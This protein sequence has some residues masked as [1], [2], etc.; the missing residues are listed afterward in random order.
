MIDQ[1][2]VLP[3]SR[4]NGYA[5]RL[6][7]HAAAMLQLKNGFLFESRDAQSDHFYEKNKFRRVGEWYAYIYRD[8]KGVF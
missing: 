7:S 1:L 8:V 5:V 6:L 4:G 3:G 2:A